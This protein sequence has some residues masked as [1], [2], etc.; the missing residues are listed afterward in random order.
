M[1]IHLFL[2]AI[3]TFTVGCSA[4]Y[5]AADMP[6]YPDKPI[7]MIAPFPPGGPGDIV[8]REIGQ[9]IGKDWGQQVVVN[10]HRM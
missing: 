2:A 10:S 5:A 8:A 9:R 7:R 3:L 4:S 6:S 1:K